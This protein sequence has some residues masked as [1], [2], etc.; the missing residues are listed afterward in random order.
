M[1]KGFAFEGLFPESFAIDSFKDAW[2]ADIWDGGSLGLRFIRQ[3]NDWEL[4][5]VDIFFGRLH[6]YSTSLE[7]DNIMV[8]VETKNSNFSVK[9]FYSS[10]VSRR[11]EPFPHMV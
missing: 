5:E 10:L 1:A 9:S 11:A 3:L 8:R 4:E 2:V 7:I 6:D